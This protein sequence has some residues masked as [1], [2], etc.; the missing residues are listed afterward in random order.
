MESEVSTI[1]E[2]QIFSLVEY[3]YRIGRTIK[4]VLSLCLMLF[5]D[6]S[7][8]HRHSII[9]G[10]INI[11]NTRC[12]LLDNTAVRLVLP[13]PSADICEDDFSI[14]GR[15]KTAMN[16]NNAPEIKYCRSQYITEEIDVF[17]AGEIMYYMLFGQPYRYNKYFDTPASD[18]ETLLLKRY[19]DDNDNW[20]H[21]IAELLRLCLKN[22][23]LYRPSAARSAL[24]LTELLV[25]DY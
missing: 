5:L 25:I 18:F 15:M 7:D 17:N 12:V 13:N 19:G 8:M 14:I 21:K 20:Y 6:I 9:H 23:C 2:V 4:Q 16:A 11:H 1:Q 22:D 10:H 3:V 24:M